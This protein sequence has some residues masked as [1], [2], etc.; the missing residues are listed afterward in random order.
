MMND[1][2]R[3]MSFLPNVIEGLPSSFGEGALE[4]IVLGGFRGLLC[5]NLARGE[6]PH[7]F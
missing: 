2:E 4:K 7:A 3:V 6:D 5:A 1:K